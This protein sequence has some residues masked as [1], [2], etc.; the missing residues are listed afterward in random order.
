MVTHL[1]VKLDVRAT[2]RGDQLVGPVPPRASGRVVG[3]IHHVVRRVERRRNRLNRKRRKQ[4]GGVCWG[5]NQSTESRLTLPLYRDHPNNLSNF[6]QLADQSTNLSTSRHSAL[7]PPS[8]QSNKVTH[9]T[10]NLITPPTRHPANQPNPQPTDKFS[11]PTQPTNQLTSTQPRIP[12]PR[13][14]PN[15]HCSPGSPY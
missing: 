1:H 11:Q 7:Q 4:W 14:N 10:N 13:R 15:A 2:L 9:P 8:I 5:I 12:L 6:V 3:S